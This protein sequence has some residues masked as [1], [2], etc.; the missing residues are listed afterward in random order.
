MINTYQTSV[1]APPVPPRLSRSQQVLFPAPSQGHSKS[2]LR[3]L[4][5]VVMLHLFLSV[6]GFIYLK[7]YDTMHPSQLPS[8]EEKCMLIELIYS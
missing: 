4:A 7:Q 2:L 8:G 3:F 6:G 5:G 1:A